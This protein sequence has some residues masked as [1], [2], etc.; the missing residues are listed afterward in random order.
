MTHRCTCS[1][2]MGPSDQSV[3]FHWPSAALRDSSMSI[4]AITT[5]IMIFFCRNE[6]LCSFNV[7]GA[8]MNNK[9][10]YFVPLEYFRNCSRF[11]SHAVKSALTFAMTLARV[12]FSSGAIMLRAETTGYQQMDSFL[13][14]IKAAS[15]LWL[16]ETRL[17]RRQ[18]LENSR[19]GALKTTYIA[20]FSGA[21]A[22][23]W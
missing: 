9:W 1:L 5:Y 6:K 4:P 17:E 11:Q 20:V 12:L 2:V 3:I 15:E 7:V 10:S 22:D 19:S 21:I 23:W 13:A 16:S 8:N 14:Q 18:K